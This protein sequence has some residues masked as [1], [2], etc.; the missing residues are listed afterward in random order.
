MA[1]SFWSCHRH[2]MQALRQAFPQHTQLFEGFPSFPYNAT[3]V[4]AAWQSRFGTG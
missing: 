4:P 1:I 3:D 2:M